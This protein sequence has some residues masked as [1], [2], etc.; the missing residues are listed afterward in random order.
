MECWKKTI[1]QHVFNWEL[2]PAVINARTEKIF[3][4]I[5]N[6]LHFVRDKKFF[7]FISEN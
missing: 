4:Y 7:Q 6:Q 5:I 2:F 3:E 1:S